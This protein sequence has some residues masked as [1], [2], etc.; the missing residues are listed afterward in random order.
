MSDELISVFYTAADAVLANSGHEP[1]G[2]VGL[3]VMAAGGIAFVGTTGEDYAVPF[4]NCIALD[5]DDPTEINIGLDFLRRHPDVVER[6]RS[7]AQ[8][9]AE[10]FSW[11][12]V[13]ED[14]LLGKLRYVALR[15]LVSPPGKSEDRPPRR[16]GRPGRARPEGAQP[17][18]PAPQTDEAPARTQPDLLPNRRRARPTAAN[19][20]TQRPLRQAADHRKR[21]ETAGTV[22]ENLVTY[23]VVHQ[24][25]RIRLPAQVD[26]QGTKP[27]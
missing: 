10:S 6:M 16:P 19:R 18:R 21:R 22:A 13:V 12:N 17:R 5:T 24:P 2:L 7:D 23:C 25:R 15:Q 11:K 14:N 27:G 9:T 4:L 1:F 8:E 26:P 3:E 20:V